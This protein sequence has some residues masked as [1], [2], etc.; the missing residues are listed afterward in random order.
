MGVLQAVLDTQFWLATH[1]TCINLGYA[2][3]FIAGIWACNTSF[4][5]SPPSRWTRKPKKICRG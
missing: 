2:T 4:K 1:V 5:V 3:M